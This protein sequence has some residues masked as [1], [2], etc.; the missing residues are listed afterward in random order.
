MLCRALRTSSATCR[1]TSGSTCRSL[2]KTRSGRASECQQGSCTPPR[3]PP[4]LD[5]PHTP[6]DEAQADAQLAELCQRIAE[7]CQCARS[8]TRSIDVRGIFPSPQHHA[9][10]AQVCLIYIYGVCQDVKDSV[11]VMTQHK[12]NAQSSG[13]ETLRG[14]LQVRKER[15]TLDMQ[16]LRMERELARYGETS[17]C[18]SHARATAGQSTG[19]QHLS[20]PQPPMCAHD[21]AHNV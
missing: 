10:L 2:S 8:L 21:C 1:Q 13:L 18:A 15:M 9:E 3:Y 11:N 17:A 7:V 16:T 12:Q 19:D 4:A 14:L 6:E 5:V 20:L